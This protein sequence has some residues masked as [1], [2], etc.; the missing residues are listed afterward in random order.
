MKD[1]TSLV[2]L[3]LAQNLVQKTC[4]TI[5]GMTKSK[6]FCTFSPNAIRQ[7]HISAPRTAQISQLLRDQDEK[8]GASLPESHHFVQ[9]FGL[10]LVVGPLLSEIE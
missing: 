7:V 9:H 2:V 6:I 1:T 8:Y 3:I 5:K 4:Q 10:E